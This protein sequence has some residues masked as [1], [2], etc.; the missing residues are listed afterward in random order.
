MVG[1]WVL[2]GQSSL[3]CISHVS[4]ASTDTNRIWFAFCDLLSFR[5]WKTTFWCKEIHMASSLQVNIHHRSW[6]RLALSVVLVSLLGA[7]SRARCSVCGLPEVGLRRGR[8]RDITWSKMQPPCCRLEH[9]PCSSPAGG[10]RRGR[11]QKLDFMIN[12]HLH[13]DGLDFVMTKRAERPVK[14]TAG[15]P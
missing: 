5:N 11:C 6:G 2:H 13:R 9:G 8:Q 14:Q 3:T 10:R 1:P 15:L 12:N 7:R 4:P